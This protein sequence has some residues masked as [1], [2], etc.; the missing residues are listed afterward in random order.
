M[1][2]GLASRG[3]AGAENGGTLFSALRAKRDSGGASRFFYCP[4]APKKDKGAD[5]T[6]PTVKNTKLMSYLINLV[7]PPGGVVLDPFMG[8][9]STGVSA[10][11][12]GFRFTGIEGET[13]YYLIAADR[14]L[15]ELSLQTAALIHGN[16]IGTMA[17]TEGL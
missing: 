16:V 14:T 2:Q 13:V 11:R 9:G 8:S 1:R 5:N 10:I 3:T 12:S 6:H 7:T 17:Y 15:A 4:K